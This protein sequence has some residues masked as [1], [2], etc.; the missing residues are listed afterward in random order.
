MFDA[1]PDQAIPKIVMFR[2]KERQAHGET[3]H[4]G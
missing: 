2:L 4:M 1:W 3:K